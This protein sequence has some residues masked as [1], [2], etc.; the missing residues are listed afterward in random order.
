MPSVTVFLC[1]DFQDGAGTRDSALTLLLKNA[2]VAE[3]SSLRSK[4]VYSLSACLSNNAQVQLKFGLLGGEAKLSAMYDA[5]G[6]DSR[7]RTKVLVLLSDLLN[8][9]ARGSPAAALAIMP[10]GSTPK[11][12]GAW[13]ARADEALQQASSPVT[14]E[15]ALEA[16]VS[17]APSCG[18]Q[19]VGLGVK[20]RLNNLAQQCRSSATVGSEAGEVE[21]HEELAQKFVEA[22]VVLV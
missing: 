21:F 22:A 2:V 5:D 16:V 8:E 1:V 10:V 7:L 13:C 11:S 6:S 3:T 18:D 14:L 9:A 15:K 19:F 4:V 17:F 12:G 20:Q